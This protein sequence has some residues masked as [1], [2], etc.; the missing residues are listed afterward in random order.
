MRTNTT[1]LKSIRKYCLWCTNG[2]AL[3]VKLCPSTDCVLFP[4]RFGRGKKGILSL[5]S[6][7]KRCRECGEGT[8]QAVRKC[9]IQDCSLYAYRLGHNPARKGLGGKGVENFKKGS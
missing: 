3:E 7:K 8:T 6:I 1:P 9:E 4:L 5:G 2:Q